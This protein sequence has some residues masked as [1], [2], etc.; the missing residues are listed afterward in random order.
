VLRD[1]DLEQI[2]DPSSPKLAGEVTALA[3][4]DRQ[5]MAVALQD[6][7]V[8]IAAD[9]HEGLV[10]RMAAAQAAHRVRADL[11]G[12]TLL[13]S[14]QRQLAAAL[15]QLGEPAAALAVATAALEDWTADQ[16]TP[17]RDWLEAAVLRLSACSPATP[18][19]PVVDRLIAEAE[20]GGAALGLGARIW[21]AVE[22]LRTDGQ[23]AEALDLADQAAAALDEHSGALGASADRWRLL[24][25]LH[26]GR[27]GQPAMT[28]RL[29]A[30]LIA[31]G[32]DKRERDA[33]AVLYACAGPR[34]D[35]R[36]QNIILEAKLDA[37]SPDADDDRLRLHHA[38]AANY[39]SLGGYRQALAHGMRELELRRDLQGPDH[40]DTLTVRGRVALWTGLSGNRGEALR[41][42]LAL[43]PDRTRVLGPDHADT[44]ATRNDIAGW[45][46]DCGN[47]AEALSQF[48]ALFSDS[49]RVLG[50]DHPDI[51]TIRNNIAY[52][53]AGNGD[54]AEALRLFQALLLIQARA[55]GE[56]HPD[57]LRTRSNIAGLIRIMDS[58]PDR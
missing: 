4:R 5:A 10:E 42:S 38:L 48:K 2:T 46:G 57:A 36:L 47:P 26:A 25:A 52:W 9:P 41:L 45:T 1:G 3:L 18:R 35:T 58:Q 23:R 43:L 56:D 12:R 17:D 40:P 22:L 55:L 50:P 13:P 29:L 11:P 53:T 44:L 6:E 27:A 7:A 24:L 8:S 33:E 15:E 30:P 21:A 37:L 19:T 20:A 16:G 31:S 39:D 49:E 34:A 51:L 14:V 28:G 54:Q 32:D